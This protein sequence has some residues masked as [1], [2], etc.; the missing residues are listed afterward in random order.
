MEPLITV[1][2]VTAT[3]WSAVSGES[4][5]QIHGQTLIKNPPH[6]GH[7]QSTARRPLGIVPVSNF[8]S[9]NGQANNLLQTNEKKCLC[10]FIYKMYVRSFVFRTLSNVFDG[11]NGTAWK[12]FVFVVVLVYIFQH[13]DWIRRDTEYLSIF[14]QNVGKCGP[15]VTTT[16][17]TFHAV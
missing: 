12:V 15:G 17:D 3:C 6:S 7:L 5:C 11:E 8:T 4:A 16:M 1:T 2:S 13:S 9:I 10:F 14:S